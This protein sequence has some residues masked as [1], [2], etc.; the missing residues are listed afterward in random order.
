MKR[1][2]AAE[3]MSRPVVCIRPDAGIQ[4]AVRKMRR[5]RVSGLPV[6][7]RSGRCIG[8]I[9]EGD[10]ARVAAGSGGL[11]ALSYMHDTKSPVARTHVSEVMSLHVVSA[12]EDTPAREVARLMNRHG[13][14][15]VPIMRGAELV[16]IVTRADIIGLFDRASGDIA[17]D[18]RLALRDDLLMDPAAFGIEVNHG[19][20]VLTGPLLTTREIHLIETILSEIDGVIAVD[21]SGLRGAT[22]ASA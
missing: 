18:V 9:T 2:T 13:I 11:T 8:V 14:K 17:S 10:V 1:I 5:L 22:Q 16:G 20:V 15:R 6:Q 21:A 19:V 12:E 3:I 4:E 7:D